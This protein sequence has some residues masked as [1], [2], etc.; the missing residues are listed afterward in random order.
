[1]T[2]ALAVVSALAPLQGAAAAEESGELRIRFVPDTEFKVYQIAEYD[3]AGKFTLTGEFAKNKSK[4]TGLEEAV[5]GGGIWD[6]TPQAVD[7]S[8]TGSLAE[9]LKAQIALGKSGIPAEPVV[10]A[11]LSKDSSATGNFAPVK[12]SDNIDYSGA[13][14]IE[15]LERGLYLLV[16]STTEVET[17]IKASDGTVIGWTTKKYTPYATML[18]IP[19]FNADKTSWEYSLE[20]F[21]KGTMDE[22]EE[23]VYS[24]SKVWRGDNANVRPTSIDITIIK[25]GGESVTV[26]LNSRNQW[27][28]TW[29][30]S[31]GSNY[32]VAENNVPVNYSVG[33]QRSNNSFVVTNTYTPPTPPEPPTPTPPTPTPPTPTPPTPTPPTPTPPTP[34]P[35]GGQ[36][37][38]AQR[39]LDI[40]QGVLGATRGVLG[41][42]RTG[43]NTSSLPLIVF[44][45]SGAALIGFGLYMILKK[46]ESADP[47]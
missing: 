16:G 44:A 19:S 25:N 5:E 39:R 45:G 29:Y 31:E 11:V 3:E 1:M 10:T 17:E 21:A 15:G 37:L 33:V 12:P 42:T 47:Q 30:D 32:T 14:T 20:Y 7:G 13:A 34:T 6:M 26:T 36:V 24:V 4:V 41:A 27:S 46:R 8:S 28:Y 40:A 18:A 9:T 38:G 22:S 35:P 23:R 43:D 2:A